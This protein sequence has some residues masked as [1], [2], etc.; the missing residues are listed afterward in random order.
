[1]LYNVVSFVYFCTFRVVKVYEKNKNVPRDFF[2]LFYPCCRPH[3]ICAKKLMNDLL[4]EEHEYKYR[5]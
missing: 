2:S 5:C 4:F 3:E 1:M